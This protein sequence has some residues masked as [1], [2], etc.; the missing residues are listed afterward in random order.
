V[1]TDLG[2]LPGDVSSQA[3]AINNAGQV[4]G[5]S[6]GAD[7]RARAFVWKR[8]E[9]MKALGFLPGGDNSRALDINNAGHIVGTSGSSL[10]ERAFVWTAPGGMKD[11]NVLAL[12]PSIHLIEAQAINSKGQIVAFGVDSLSEHNDE[13][14]TRVYLATPGA[15]D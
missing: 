15:G 9:G 3:V 2:T 13:G 12:S 6:V 4:V 10:G 11:L 7:G 1:L 14:P 5:W 8:N